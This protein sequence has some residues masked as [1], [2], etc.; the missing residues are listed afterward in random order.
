MWIPAAGHGEP[1]LE[2][3]F[4]QFILEERGTF[5]GAMPV[6]LP[7]HISDRVARNCMIL[8]SVFQ[9]LGYVGRCSFDLVLVGN[10]IETA[11]F[12]FIECNARWGGTSIPMTLMNRLLG[13]WTARPFASYV[14]RLKGAGWV[15]WQKWRDR[16]GKR[17]FDRRTGEGEIILLNPQSLAEADQL[18]VIAM[19]DDHLTAK[20]AVQKEFPHWARRV[21]AEEKYA[22]IAVC[23]KGLRVDSLKERN[24]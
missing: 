7:P 6:N 4:Q 16:L 2:G 18:S 24:A 20:D 5:T 19:A 9:H 8:A 23:C 11:D 17:G 13:D 14:L 12:Q 3:F 21:L 15:P 22:Q 1:V 10:S